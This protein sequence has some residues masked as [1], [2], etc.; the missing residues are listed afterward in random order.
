MSESKPVKERLYSLDLLRGLDIFFLT[1][2][3]PIAWGAHNGLG[4]FP[5]PPGTPEGYFGPVMEQLAHRWGAFHLIDIVMPMFIFM[6]GAAIPFALG[7]RLRDGKPTAAFW[8]HLLARFSL[9]WFCGMI[10][11]GNLLT[12][13]PSR[14]RLF[15]NTLQT[16]ACGYVVAALVMLIRSRWIRWTMPAVLALVYTIPL[17]V[18]GHYAPK[19][20]FAYLVEVRIVNALCGPLGLSTK[21][22]SYTW[23]A[24]I[25]MF[26]VITLLGMMSTEIIRAKDASGNVKALRLSL[27]GVGLLALG[28]ATYPVIP[29]V[30]HI[31]TLTFTA[32]AMGWCVLALAA[33]YYLTDVL[34]FRRGLG[35][36][37]LFGQFALTAYMLADTPL[38]EI[39]RC[40]AKTF[41]MG[42]EFLFGKGWATFLCSVLEGA[43]VT[44]ALVVRRRMRS[45]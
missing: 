17:A 43:L 26:G 36:F 15:D 39:T 20:N 5:V 9:L 18:Y 11:Q 40:A 25:P 42:F 31:F 34:R 24:T 21:L 27:L 10:A 2:F 33:L 6:C 28:W 13:D 19:D 45:R 30:K 4:L 1:V 12:L 3:V 37:I 38:A 35:L 23:F 41:G 8:K 14:I 22:T 29:S 16:I 44:F 32:Q 7:R